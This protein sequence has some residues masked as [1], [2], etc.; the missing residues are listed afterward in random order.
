MS[1][2]KFFLIKG[3]V[4]SVIIFFLLFSCNQKTEYTKEEFIKYMQEPRNGIIKTKKINDNISINISHRPYQFVM[5]GIKDKGQKMI[6]SNEYPYSYFIMNISRNG[7]ELLAEG[8]S[9][10]ENFSDLLNK[11]AFG[12]HDFVFA[13]TS[14]HDT[15]YMADY[16][17]SRT[18]GIAGSTNIQFAFES[19]KIMK[20]E[21]IDIHVKDFGI[22]IVNTPKFRFKV[23]DLKKANEIVILK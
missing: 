15:I 3:I 2:D 11:L 7:N 5:T 23:I 19:G 13:T 20:E 10:N 22:G 18:Y 4:F 16:N 9:S 1:I 17:M 12:M 8:F 14:N 6:S 21:W